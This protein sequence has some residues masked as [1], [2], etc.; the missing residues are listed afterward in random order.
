MPSSTMPSVKQLAVENDITARKTKRYT[1]K[2]NGF[3]KYHCQRGCRF[4]SQLGCVQINCK[5][6]YIQKYY[7]QKCKRHELPCKPWFDPD[8][9]QLMIE[10]ALLR[11]LHRP[12]FHR[13]DGQFE[14]HR[15]PH[16]PRLCEACNYGDTIRH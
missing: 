10:N 14:A 9:L 3:S 4:T 6:F 15:P 5:Q 13:I 16:I 1:V 11:A 7:V 2:A 8:L 12:T